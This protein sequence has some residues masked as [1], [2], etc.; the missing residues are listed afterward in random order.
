MVAKNFITYMKAVVADGDKLLTA[1]E[2][3]KTFPK[4]FNTYKEYSDVGFRND[5]D[6]EYE[7]TARQLLV[8]NF[9]FYVPTAEFVFEL[10]KIHKKVNKPILSVG[11]G[12]GYLERVLINSGVETI[13]T[14]LYIKDNRYSWG[15]TIWMP[16]AEC[17]SAQD[18]IKKYPGCP[19]L[20]S[21]PCYDK[22]WS[23][24]AIKE[25]TKDQ[26]LIYIGESFGGCTG[27]DA[28]HLE[29]FDNFTDS[30][31]RV[32]AVQFRG[33]HDRVHINIKY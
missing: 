23:Y 18:A 17:I 3:I 25:M 31:I 13:A 33:I 32:P 11:C 6:R 21:W 14:D 26:Y 2:T 19:V 20:M 4:V 5:E 16:Q 9:G 29:L 10:K 30:E 24:D 12:S 15:S 7:Y 1:A 27:T 28:F 22:D 8:D